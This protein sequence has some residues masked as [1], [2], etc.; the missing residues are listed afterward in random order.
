MIFENFVM[1]GRGAPTHCHVDQVTKNHGGVWIELR[2]NNPE[3]GKRK[4]K[5]AALRL[6]LED[7]EALRADLDAIIAELKKEN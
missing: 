3:R 6:T 2:A 4:K 7:A 1:N 5:R